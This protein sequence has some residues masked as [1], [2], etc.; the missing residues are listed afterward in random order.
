MRRSARA[1]TRAFVT[2]MRSTRPGMGEWEIEALMSFVHRREG[3]RGPGYGAIVGSGA[4]SLILHY[5]A[6]TRR[7]EKDDILLVDY[8]P[9]LDHFVTDITRTW[10]V[11]G[12]FSKRQAE[13]YDAVLAAQEAAIAAA[14]PGSTLAEIGGVAARTMTDLG[15]GPKYQR[16]GVCHMIGM[17]VHEKRGSA[18]LEPGM[19]FTIEPGLYDAENAIGVR[20]EDVVVITEDG[21]EVLTAAAPKQRKQI[22]KLMAEIGILERMDRPGQ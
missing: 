9:E 14:R 5:L 2:A 3:A 19:T 12:R 11:G 15:F 4:N 18:K 21:C 20:I 17:E 13:I 6:S 7:M 22:E 16:H 1:G 10:P 8:A